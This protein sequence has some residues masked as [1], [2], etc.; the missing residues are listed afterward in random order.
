VPQLDFGR[1]TGNIPLAAA[2]LKQSVH[3]RQARRV[4]VCSQ[5]QASYLGDG[6]L[7]DHLTAAAADLV[8]FTVYCW[9]VD[10]TLYLARQLK[11]GGN[12]RILV[13]GP[14][15]TADNPR[16]R[17]PEVDL[18][19]CGEGET[20]F[21]KLLDGA[22]PGAGPCIS[23]PTM[24]D[25]SRTASPYLAGLLD[26]SIEDCMLLE[27]QRGCPYGCAFCYY[28]K[29]RQTP[30]RLASALLDGALKWA[31]AADVSELYLLD[32]SLNARPDLGNFLTQIA[33]L[34]PDR[35]LGLISEIRAEAVDGPLARNLAAA[36]FTMLEVG[37]QSTNPQTWEQMGRACNL[38]RWLK[39]VAHMR[40]VGIQ[41]R[42]DL[43]L[44]L[45]GDDPQGFQA[46]VDFVAGH[47]LAMDVQVFPLALLPGTEFRNRRAE[48]GL[49]FAA[50]P[51]YPVTGSAAFTGNDLLLAMD[52]AESR[53]DTA[54][55]VMPQLDIRMPG[56]DQAHAWVTVEGEPYITALK[57]FA[58]L[59]M[60]ELRSLARR[61]THPYQ[62]LAGPQTGRG[63]YLPQALAEIT[64]INPYT[65]FEVV[66]FDPPVAPDTAKLLSALN[67]P[68]P[69][70]LDLE[71]RY[72][73]PRPGNRTVLFTVVAPERRFTFQGPMERHIR[74]WQAPAWPPE[75]NLDPESVWDGVLLDT[76]GRDGAAVKAWQD[77]LAPRA[78]ELTAMGFWER[79]WQNR[80]LQLTA[81]GE[82]YFGVRQ[83]HL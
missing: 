55:Y 49:E 51:P 32:P 20:V 63:D 69:Q 66:W 18:A 57:L 72:L 7:L 64:R 75:E 26:T 54:L 48:L 46:S 80:W 81:G 61:L 33:G 60:A 11:S 31:V 62:V 4:G 36:G 41:P 58:L 12:V 19:V 79:R 40:H 43:I 47:D 13:G 82:Y 53:L 38:D 24:A 52:Y 23:A 76:R 45:P 25:F 44:G 9:N 50:Q 27:S 2:C 78:D 1:R 21:R 5:S 14:E 30:A 83:E 39:G 28:G 17:V 67:M 65:P 6:A 70:F 8:G 35:R 22:W 71:Q 77:R 34:N 59:N 42:V 37:L 68:R 56:E 74:W 10:R 3:P 73:F 29:A 15:V 16:I